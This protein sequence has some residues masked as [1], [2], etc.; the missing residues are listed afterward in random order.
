MSAFL[1]NT[2]FISSTKKNG[3]TLKNAVISGA[4]ALY[5]QNS[6]HTEKGNYPM[7][8]QSGAITHLRG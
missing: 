1:G 2:L 5:F 7:H 4:P 8:K 3:K 6:L